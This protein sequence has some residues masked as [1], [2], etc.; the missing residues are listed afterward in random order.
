MRDYQRKIKTHVSYEYFMSKER[1]RNTSTVAVT[2]IPMNSVNFLRV[3]LSTT[4]NRQ[5][6][7]QK[8]LIP[9]IPP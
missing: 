7:R 3:K 4:I 5:E 6:R 1:R 8:I 2:G 9:V